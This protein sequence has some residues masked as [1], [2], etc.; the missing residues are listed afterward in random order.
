MPPD[1]ESQSLDFPEVPFPREWLAGAQ[2]QVMSA[3]AA[4]YTVCRPAGPMIPTRAVSSLGMA[5]GLRGRR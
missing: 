1:E 2:R 4:S 5:P 3:L